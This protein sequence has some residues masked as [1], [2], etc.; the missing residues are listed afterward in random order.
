MPDIPGKHINMLNKAVAIAILVRIPQ[1]FFITI[2]II[3][4][5]IIASLLQKIRESD[6]SNFISLKRS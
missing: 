2:D 6:I 3:I 4:A 1:P 5:V